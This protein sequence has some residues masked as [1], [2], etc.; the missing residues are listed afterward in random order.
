[1]VQFAKNQLGSCGVCNWN[2]GLEA[3]TNQ[4]WPG[5][6]MEGQDEVRGHR[7]EFLSLGEMQALNVNGWSCQLILVGFSTATGAGGKGGESVIRVFR[8]DL[9]SHHSAQECSSKMS[10][11]DGLPGSCA[12]AIYMIN[13]K[14]SRTGDEQ[15]E[16]CKSRRRMVGQNW[17]RS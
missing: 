16:L 14:K 15:D 11:L 4:G 12:W 10:G 3:A 17:V 6:V 1:M 9:V 7:W 8:C 5:E 2:M 13:S